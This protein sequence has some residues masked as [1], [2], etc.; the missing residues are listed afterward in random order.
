MYTG[1]SLNF[2]K[3]GQEPLFVVNSAELFGVAQGCTVPRGIIR[4]PRES[5]IR[6]SVEAAFGTGPL[7]DLWFVVSSEL[8][9]SLSAVARPRSQ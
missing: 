3:N 4:I 1:C 9:V 5:T 6:V 2:T 7:R 8:L